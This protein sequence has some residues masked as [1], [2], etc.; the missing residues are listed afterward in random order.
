MCKYA[1][2]FILKLNLLFLFKVWL[3]ILG[4]PEQ[5]MSIQV[6]SLSSTSIVISWKAGLD[7]GYSQHFIINYCRIGAW[8]CSNITITG[9]EVWETVNY[10]IQHL[11]P[12]QKY[13][14]QI[15]AVNAFHGR[16]ENASNVVF[17]ATNGVC[18]TFELYA[19]F[20]SSMSTCGQTRQK[21][22][23]LQVKRKTIAPLTHNFFSFMF[24]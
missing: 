11:Q 20:M 23:I 9:V 5:P 13:K 8:K 10:T 22:L 21:L 4:P 2:V 24:V 19:L 12:Q 6:V 7:G 15:V 17:I 18:L 16:A 14:V 3:Y 1:H